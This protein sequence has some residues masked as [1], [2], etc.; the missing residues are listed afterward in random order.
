MGVF[1][2]FSN[3]MSFIMRLLIP[4]LLLFL[5]TTQAQNVVVLDSIS[6]KP[7]PLVNI[8][9]GRTGVITSPSG[10]FFWHKPQTDS[11]IL[12]CLGYARKKIAT[13][14]IS[15]TLYML[16]KAIELMPVM[17][18]NRVL[19]AEEI[20]DSI[21]ANTKKNVDF[22]LSASEVFLHYTDTYDF[23]K[24]DI[25]I[26]KS[27]IPELDQHFVHEILE[28]VPKKEIEESFSKSKW[29]RDNSGLKHHK[30][31]VLK[32]VRL[33]DSLT[34]NRFYSLGKTINDILKKRVKKDSYFKVK[35]GPLI[36]IKVDNLVNEVDTLEQKKSVITPKE[37]AKRQLG[38]LQR[39]A[40]KD[41]FVENHWALPFLANPNKYQFTNEGVV[42]DMGVPTYKIR[43][44]SRKKKDY[45]GYLIVDVEDFGVYK[46]EYLSN[47]HENKIKLFGLFYEERLNNK[48]YVFVKTH[49]GKY[50][51]YHIHEEYQELGGLKRPLKIIEKNKVVKGK[52]RQNVLAMDIHF[53]IKEIY[54]VSAYFNSF[55]PISKATFDAFKLRH[56]VIPENLHS[57]SEIKKKIPDLLIE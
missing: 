48:T 4:F 26:K 42:Y 54:Q 9:D 43:F 21:K 13:A 57:K 10:T 56:S 27:T 19:S 7:I 12:S 15:D 32:A 36:T 24:M 53:S 45:N 17:V 31:Q 20:I 33:H 39:L 29:L 35:S 16:P 22:G 46:I 47:Q 6:N 37:Y 18:S 41:L 55:T 34:K 28:Q 40:I 38:R 5:N 1:F 23:Q 44:T 14:H 52:N 3:T 2:Y 8:Y 25:E 11:I 50:T 51:L 30:F 49:L